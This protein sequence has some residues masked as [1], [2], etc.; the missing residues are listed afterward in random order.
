MEPGMPLFEKIDADTISTRPRQRRQ[1]HGQLDAPARPHVAVE[2]S[3]AS[4]HEPAGGAMA[5][6]EGHVHSG[7]ADGMKAPRPGADVPE[8]YAIAERL[9]GAEVVREGTR[10]EHLM[11]GKLVAI[12]FDQ[13]A[14]EHR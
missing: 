6:L 9:V 4:L 2:E 3:G 7:P 5:D 10:R 12:A 1:R 11:P 14:A 13:P 8:C